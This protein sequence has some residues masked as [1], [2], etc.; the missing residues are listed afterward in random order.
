MLLTL[1]VTGVLATWRL[2]SWTTVKQQMRRRRIMLITPKAAVFCVVEA[3]A[4]FSFSS[5]WCACA[6]LRDEGDSEG[7]DEGKAG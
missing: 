7:E 3:V 4:W 5:R 6:R 1:T 2:T